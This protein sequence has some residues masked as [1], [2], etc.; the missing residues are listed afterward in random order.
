MFVLLAQGQSLGEAEKLCRDRTNL[1]QNGGGVR[2]D[3]GACDGDAAPH[4]GAV[5][6]VGAG[7]AGADVVRGDGGIESVG[8]AGENETG[9]RAL[10][11]ADEEA[12]QGVVATDGYGGADADVVADDGGWVSGQLV[13]PA[14]SL[15]PGRV[16][17]S[18][19][20]P[21]LLC[22]VRPQHPNP[23]LH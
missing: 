13:G 4:D 19:S 3:G 16:H 14:I 20:V 1:H 18:R 15:S 8:N 22:A 2:R 9:W 6:R 10:G 7:Y 17:S 5:V 12:G 11:V 21:C 23:C